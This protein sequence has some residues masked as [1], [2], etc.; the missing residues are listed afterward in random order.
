MRIRREKLKINRKRGRR[1]SHRIQR[2]TI[3]HELRRYGSYAY[4]VTCI[5]E[6]ALT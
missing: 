6:R 3:A 5:A 1:I 2:A 4:G